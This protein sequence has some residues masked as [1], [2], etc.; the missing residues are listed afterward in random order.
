LFE[1]MVLPFSIESGY[2]SAL[3]SLYS[4]NIRYK[5]GFFA[6][7]A[8]G[9]L[10]DLFAVV[11]LALGSGNE[12]IEADARAARVVFALDVTG[13]ILIMKGLVSPGIIV[14]LIPV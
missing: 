8:T 9:R 13:N 5:S 10:A 14:A 7:C 1:K 4:G 12:L 11:F 3:E 6:V 2:G